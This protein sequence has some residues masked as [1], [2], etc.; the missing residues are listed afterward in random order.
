[1]LL[2][3][4]PLLLAFSLL[5]CAC[6]PAA[7]PAAPA[8]PTLPAGAI[9]QVVRTDGSAKPFTLDDIKKLPAVQASMDG[10]NQNGP[11]LTTLLSAA[12][13]TTYREVTLTGGGASLTLTPNQVAGQTMLD[14]NNRGLVKLASL[15][16]P[17][18]QWVKDIT[19]IQVK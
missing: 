2:R 9:L 10:I 16:V 13:V 7:A 5:L 18:D 8:A 15:L 1:M 17:K 3:T 6:S 11:L 19:L 14:F 4:L 12:G